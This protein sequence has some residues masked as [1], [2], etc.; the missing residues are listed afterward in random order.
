MALRKANHK[1]KC[2]V[3]HHATIIV[4]YVLYKMTHK[5]QEYIAI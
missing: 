5:T 2:Q 3:F 4:L 1:E